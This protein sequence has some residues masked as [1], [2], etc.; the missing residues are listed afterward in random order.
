MTSQKPNLSIVVPVYGCR[1]T[2][3]DLAEQVFELEP[4]IGPIELILV[5]DASIDG[6]WQV[7]ETLTELFP[8]I[9]A[10]R[11][12]RNRG[13]HFAISVGIRTSIGTRVAIMDCDLENSPR[14]IP[15]LLALMSAI[16]HCVI[17]NSESRSS[18][19]GLRRLLRALYARM[20]SA[21]YRMDSI[22]L[23][24]SS[25]SFCVIDGE[26]AR[27]LTNKGDPADPIS[28]KILNSAIGL[29]SV[30]VETTMNRQRH[31][32]YSFSDNLQVAF[33]SILL[34]GKGFQ[35]ICIKA[36]IAAFG[37]VLSF[38]VATVILL[39][40]GYDL[41]TYISAVLL[42]LS[43]ITLILAWTFLLA[44]YQSSHNADAT[45]LSIVEY[46]I[47]QT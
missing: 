23:G 34:S 22:V 15:R 45:T 27:A 46:E 42:S 39:H 40:L 26:L 13:Q 18:K 1:D 44:T 33:K 41:L 30:Q 20:L 25:F 10:V 24:V 47:D 21:C 9:R 7:I 11:L 16:C 29:A 2:L 4:E 35:V 32:A 38:T 28:L 17:G 5:D 14:D 43:S 3:K 36:C 37:A 8:H 12:L 19:S 31:S 6:S